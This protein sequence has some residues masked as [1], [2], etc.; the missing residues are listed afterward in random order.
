MASRWWRGKD[1]R[2]QESQT[3]AA[4]AAV[5][6]ATDA[7]PL[8]L[9]EP[10]AIGGVILALPIG[11]LGPRVLQERG[12]VAPAVIREKHPWRRR[13]QGIEPEAREEPIR[14][15][16]RQRHHHLD[17]AQQLKNLGFLGG[18]KRGRE[19]SRWGGGAEESR[20]EWIASARRDF[21]I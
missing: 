10:S 19:D 16:S 1:R 15:S 20:C 5:I 7:H 3:T 4:A 18:R 11:V 2:R 13:A 8:P 17:R 6:R 12:L 21:N 14:A 9:P